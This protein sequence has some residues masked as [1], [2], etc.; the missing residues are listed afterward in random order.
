MTKLRFNFSSALAVATDLI[1][2]ACLRIA[3]AIFLCV[4]IICASA[5]S[6]FAQAPGWSRGQQN[7]AISYDEC[8][9][10]MPAALEAEGYGRDPN[11]GGNFVAGSKGVHTAVIICSPAPEARMLVQIVVASNGD[12][13]GAE[14]QRLQKQM[15]QPGSGSSLSLGGNWCRE[16]DRNKVASIKQSGNSLT[17]TNEFGNSS[18]GSFENS[19]TVV[20]IDWQ[21]GLRGTVSSDGTRINWAN[22][23]SWQRCGGR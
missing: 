9:R 16:G 7:L 18:R 23:T 8:V 6:S 2:A 15:E 13:G 19:N 17:F 1:N 21:G 11:S 20:A 12:G 3:A 10:R 22:N 14:R 5:Y 4:L